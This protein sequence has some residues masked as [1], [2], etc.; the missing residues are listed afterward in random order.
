MKYIRI[1]ISILFIILFYIECIIYIKI[2]PFS[3]KECNKKQLLVTGCSTNH[4]HLL[5][6]MLYKVFKCERDICFIIWDLG[7]IPSQKMKLNKL[8]IYLNKKNTY[9]SVIFNIF[10]YSAYPKFFNIKKNAGQYAWKPIIIS[11]TYYKYKCT[12]LWLDV[13]CNIIGSLQ[14][15]YNDIHK[16]KVWSI[17]AGRDI[18]RYTHI[19]TLLYLN[20]SKNIYKN[21]MCAGGVVGFSYPHLLA[22][23]L[24]QKWV[25]CSMEKECIAPKYSNRT[26]HRQDQSVF[27]ILLYQLKLNCNRGSK[28]YN[29][30]THFDRYYKFYNNSEYLNLLETLFTKGK[31]V[32]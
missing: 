18:K 19:S 30:T 23:I 4:F 17:G 26:N 14:S 24:L 20:A 27:T 28:I 32:V 31:N 6:L 29:F 10:N 3:R 8:Y 15:V 7:I 12:L 22:N 2:S 25:S 9:I 11:L 21:I 16:Y 5:L 1:F 13:G